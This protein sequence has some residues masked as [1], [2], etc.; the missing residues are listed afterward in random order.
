MRGRGGFVVA[1]VV[2]MLFAISVAGM[3][4]Y[5]VVSSEFEL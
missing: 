5:I 3:T 1:F 2:F 4:G